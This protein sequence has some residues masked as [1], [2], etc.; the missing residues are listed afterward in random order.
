MTKKGNIG[1]RGKETQDWTW[2]D[3]KHT[4]RNYMLYGISGTDKNGH[5]ETIHYRVM[6][7]ALDIF[8]EI[9]SLI[10][11]G[12]LRDPKTGKRQNNSIL[13]RIIFT[14]GCSVLL[15]ILKEDKEVNGSLSQLENKLQMLN[16]IRKKQ[17][18]SELQLEAENLQEEIIRSNLKDKTEV[19]QK[20][21]SI[22]NEIFA[23]LNN[24]SL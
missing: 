11:D 18:L 22:S 6:P 16:E 15:Q 23:I 24:P 14:V 21:E 8:A 13:H 4:I 1:T 17:R 10:P 9:C 7:F 3:F 20:I 12:W 2:T 5:S 19:V